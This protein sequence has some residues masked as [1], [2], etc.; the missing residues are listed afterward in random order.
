ME[1]A[2]PSYVQARV[3]GKLRELRAQHRLVVIFSHG[4]VI[5][6]TMAYF[7]GVPLDLFFRITI[8]AASINALESG[9]D[10]TR[11]FLLNGAADPKNLLPWLAAPG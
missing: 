1:M 6:A 8:D 4:D 10:F 9:D 11:I 5:R 3:I 7:L 2:K